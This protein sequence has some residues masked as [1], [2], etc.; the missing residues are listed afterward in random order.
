M[1]DVIV[2]GGGP[3][4]LMLA[5]ELR[6]AGVRTVVLEKLAEP[7]RESR[8]RGLH[9]RSVEVMDQRG[10]L[11]RFLAVS[12][13]FQVGGFFGGSRS[14]GRSCW[15]RPTRTVSP[16]S[17]RSPSGCSGSGPSSW[18]PRSGPATRWSRWARTRR[19]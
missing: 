14:R 12:E 8:G 4:G 11:D 5:C 10:L 17:S 1:I 16:P 9:V 19:R 7:T 15:T 18:A 3:T 2:V 6:L 13:K